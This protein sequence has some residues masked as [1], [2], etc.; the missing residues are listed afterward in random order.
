VLLFCCVFSLQAFLRDALKM[1]DAIVT[2]IS[3]TLTLV[4]IDE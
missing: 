3:C 1:Y 4:S 2:E